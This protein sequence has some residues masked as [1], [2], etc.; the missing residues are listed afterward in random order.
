MSTE[1]NKTKVEETTNTSN[2]LMRKTKA[3]LV[4]IILRKD[5]VERELR[6][7]FS[8]AN[9]KLAKAENKCLVYQSKIENLTDELAELKR[10]YEDKCDNATSIE[11]EYESKLKHSNRTINILLVVLLIVAVMN[12]ISF[13]L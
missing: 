8:C 13:I 11:F 1:T 7:N 4:D 6:K 12:F 9:D 10:D 2:S 5:S 3:Q